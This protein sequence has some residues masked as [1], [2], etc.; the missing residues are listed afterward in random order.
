MINP[1]NE[2][3]GMLSSLGK[4]DATKVLKIDTKHVKVNIENIKSTLIKGN[5]AAVI[6]SNALLTTSELSLIAECAEQGQTQCIV[7]NHSVRL[8]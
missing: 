1:E 5:C 3:L 2:P 8:H 7:L 4:I 6:L